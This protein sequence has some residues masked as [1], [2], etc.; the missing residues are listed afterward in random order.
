M[1]IGTFEAKNKLS[2]LL[3]R[4][5]RGETIQITRRGKAIA[6]LRPIAEEGRVK[7]RF[8]SAS[9]LIQYISDDF[10]EPLNDFRDYMPE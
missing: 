6:E 2:A 10:H 7:P 1:K 9:D 4:V 8:G 5:V 3:D